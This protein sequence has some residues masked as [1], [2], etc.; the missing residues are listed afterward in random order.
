MM[1]WEIKQSEAPGK[2][3]SFTV[4]TFLKTTIE[5]F[6]VNQIYIYQQVGQID[7]NNPEV[8]KYL[9]RILVQME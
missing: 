3:K 1:G 6:S 9:V 8:T 4:R 5:T 2:Q 7:W